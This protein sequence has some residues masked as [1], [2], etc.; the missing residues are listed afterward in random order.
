MLNWILLVVCLAFC[1]ILIKR[2][3]FFSSNTINRNQ[4]IGF[5]GFKLFIA[6]VLWFIYTYYYT[7]RTTADIFRYFDDALVLFRNRA[8]HPDFFYK[9]LFGLP[10]DHQQYNALYDQMNNWNHQSEFQLFKDSHL[11]IRLNTVFCFFTNGFYPI[12]LLIFT[13]LGFVGTM[14]IFK[15]GEKF[16]PNSAKLFLVLVFFTPSILLWTAGI[17][18][19]TILFFFIGLGLTQLARNTPNWILFCLCYIGIWLTKPLI[20][21]LGFLPLLVMLPPIRT[22]IHRSIY[23]YFTTLILCIL[24]GYTLLFQPHFNC[25][26][27]LQH[28]QSEFLQLAKISKTTIG[29]PT[30]TENHST[31]FIGS[32]Q[33]IK[34]ALF[35]PF[36]PQK[37]IL[38]LLTIL[39]NWFFLGICF[40]FCFQFLQLK[41]KFWPQNSL[42]LACFL[43]VFPLLLIIGFTTPVV[44]AL[45]RY[46]IPAIPFLYLGFISLIRKDNGVSKLIP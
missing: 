39:E 21:Y 29:L 1:L 31:L 14:G 44:G 30:L 27:V 16:L 24:I 35:E 25:F 26:E 7:D 32:F 6:I 19:E 4:L 10:I 3:S 45:V 11:L 13:F 20:A 22:W 18:K 12:H 33:A 41:I 36:R 15:V 38:V 5:F 23:N 46:R 8:T 2:H 17:L 28:K 43:F 34:N 42:L 9:C 40:Y 37:G